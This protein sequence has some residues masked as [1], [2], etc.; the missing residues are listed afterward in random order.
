MNKTVSPIDPE[1]RLVSTKFAPPRIGWRHIAR[2]RLLAALRQDQH[3]KLTFITGS[4]GF[5][6]TILLAQWRQELMRSG[7]KVAWL[8]LTE[9]E[10]KLAG[11]RVHL[12]AACARLAEPLRTALAG[13]AASPYAEDGITALVNCLAG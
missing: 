9:D 2:T 6:K 13:E 10:R 3:R 5:G 8:S 4:A 12:F 1:S 11:F 7:F